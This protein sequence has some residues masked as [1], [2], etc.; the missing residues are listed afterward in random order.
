M[1]SL[2]PLALLDMARQL[3]LAAALLDP[4]LEADMRALEALWA[5]SVQVRPLF[6]LAWT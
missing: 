5:A 2:A 4:Q 1:G 3:S 6:L